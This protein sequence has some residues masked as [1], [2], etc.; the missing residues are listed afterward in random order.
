M[1]KHFKDYTDPR[2]EKFRAWMD[3]TRGIIFLGGFPT[4]YDARQAIIKRSII[5]GMA[6]C[7]DT[8]KIRAN[9]Q[10]V[11]SGD[12]NDLP[13]R[14]AEPWASVDDLVSNAG[15]FH[16]WMGGSQPSR[17]MGTDYKGAYDTLDEARGVAALSTNCTWY[18]I[19][20]ADPTN[21]GDLTVVQ[22]GS[23]SYERRAVLVEQIDG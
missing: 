5:E 15:P 11:E 12:V 21:G 13:N 17:G 18:Q 14:P 3:G 4:K 22:R 10:I 9:G 23:I 20:Q 1:D 8:Y 6:G 2:S 7:N 19:A 16:L